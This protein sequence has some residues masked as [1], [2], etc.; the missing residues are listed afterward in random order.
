MKRATKGRVDLDGEAAAAMS[1]MLETL[2]AEGEC[3]KITASALASWIVRRFHGSDFGR[4]KRRLIREHLDP[5]GYLRSVV[6]A[7]EAGEDAGE[8]LGAALKKMR[9][10]GAKGTRKAHMRDSGGHG[11]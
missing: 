10:R 7:V 5:K 2:R 4:Q 11:V 6:K 1:S 3:V 8:A 9:G